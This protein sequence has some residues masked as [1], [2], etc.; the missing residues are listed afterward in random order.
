MLPL[1]DGLSV[2]RNLWNE[3]NNFHGNTVG[4]KVDH[5]QEQPIIFWGLLLKHCMALFPSKAN[6]K[7]ST[8]EWCFFL[9]NKGFK[10]TKI[11]KKETKKKMKSQTKAVG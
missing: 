10:G 4:G 8:K 11:N 6:L 1:P 3:P 2:G 9:L 5:G 7:L